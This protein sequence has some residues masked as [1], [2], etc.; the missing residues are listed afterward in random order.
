MVADTREGEVYGKLLEKLDAARSALQGRVFDVLGNLFENVSLKELLW[1]AIQ[2]GEQDNETKL[3]EAIE[4]IV[5]I[6][7]IKSIIEDKKL[8][9]DRCRRNR[10]K[11][12]AGYGA[13]RSSALATTPIEGF[14]LEALKTRWPP[15]ITRGWTI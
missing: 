9:R 7:H 5:D 1:E 10:F 11:R 14:F 4:G 13:C 12:S 6:E 8:T 2:Y 15:K 3:T